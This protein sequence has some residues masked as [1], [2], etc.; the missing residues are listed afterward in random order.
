MRRA[1]VVGIDEYT[2]APLA[3]CVNDANSMA[4]VL[5]RNDDESPNFDVKVLTAPPTSIS[6]STLRQAVE[7]LFKSPADIALFYF[8]GHGTE[9]NLGGFMVTQDAQKYDEG[10]GLSDVLTLANNSPAREAVIMLDSCH[11]GAMGEIPALMNANVHIREG[12]SILTASRSS[13][14]AVESGGVGLF[15]G[16][17]VAA[18]EGGAAD[19]LGQ[20]KLPSVYSYVDES[21]GSWDQR[22]LFKA[23][24]STLV[25]LRQ[26]RP[27]IDVSIL[28]LLPQWFPSPDAVFDLDPSYEPDSLPS[29]VDHEQIFGYLQKC[30]AAHLVEPVDEDHMYF[31]AMNSKGCALTPLGRHYW[32][33][34]NEG[35]L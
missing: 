20:V 9:N 14:Y 30:R 33:L 28:R 25:P 32:R 6:R 5:K 19:N 13:E 3:G 7:A 11:S 15:T 2:S 26:A 35:R 4:S 24:V 29:D 23:H 8:S 34:A 10:V 27:R 17:V 16:L 22:P 1:L 12:V 31:A 18:L 21:L